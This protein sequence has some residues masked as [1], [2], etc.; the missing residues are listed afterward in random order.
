[1]ASIAL[2]VVE[3]GSNWPAF[4]CGAAHDV[5]GLSQASGEPNGVT[6]QRVCD[7]AEHSRAAVRLAVLAC[8]ADVDDES[9]H[10]RAFTASRLLTAV[11]HTD[12][13]Q[14]ILS[15][16]GC[17]SAALRLGI[18]GLAAT[19]SNVVLESLASVSVRIGDGVVW[20]SV[21]RPSRAAGAAPSRAE[22]VEPSFAA[23][24]RDRNAEGAALAL[25]LDCH[26]SFPQ[27]W[28][29]EATAL[30]RSQKGGVRERKGLPS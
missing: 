23:A 2:V 14:L 26:S 22:I 18:V 1:M 6:L 20:Y 15:G 19:L 28:R 13:G 5:V 16:S 27:T 30:E 24:L 10:Q 29:L 11:A 8:N 17:A 25:G 7:R 9:I 4:V 3:P 12:G 21:A